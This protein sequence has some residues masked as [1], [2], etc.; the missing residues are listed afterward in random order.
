[1]HPITTLTAGL[2]ALSVA[3]G[4]LAGESA[5]VGRLRQDGTIQ[6]YQDRFLKAF[7]DGTPVATIE[8]TP[9]PGGPKLTR[10]AADGCL[11]ETT[12]LRVAESPA[13]T[14]PAGSGRSTGIRSS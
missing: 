6:V 7:P 2:L 11:T 5:L 9:A 13:P 8:A 12:V 4:A 1:M 10:A 3:S 14:G